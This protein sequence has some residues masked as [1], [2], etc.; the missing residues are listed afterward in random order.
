MD[1][2]LRRQDRCFV[3][4]LWL[5]V[6]DRLRL[7]VED[8]SFLV[9]DPDD[10]VRRHDVILTTQ[11]RSFDDR[12]LGAVL[13]VVEPGHDCRGDT[14]TR[15]APLRYGM[16]PGELLLLMYFPLRT[17][18]G[19]GFELLNGYFQQTRTFTIRLVPP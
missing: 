16:S 15:R 10:C 9:I 5:H 3:D 12:F 1:M 17:V 18:E 19:V 11:N 14:P 4:C 6:P 2:V 7:N 13:R 8:A